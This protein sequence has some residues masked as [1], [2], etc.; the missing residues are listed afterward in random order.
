MYFEQIVRTDIGCAAY[1]I[2]SAFGEAAV[3]DPRLDMVDELLALI[4]REKLRLRYII[5]THNH[6]DHVSGH[7]ALAARTGATIA[8][9]EAAGVAYPHQALRDAEE[10]TLGEVRLRVLHTPGHRPEHIAIAVSDTA[11]GT[12]PWLVLTGDSLFIGDVARPDLAVPGQEGAAALFHSLRERL[13]TLPDGTLVYPAHVSGSLC[14]RVTNRMTMTTL[15]YERAFNPALA[16][17]DEAAFVHYTTE[18]LPERPPNMVR[19]VE[20]NKAA[21]AA[22]AWVG[23]LTPLSASEVSRLRTDGAIVLDVRSVELFTEGHLPGAI[24]VQIESAQFPNRVG[25]TLPAEADLVIV[26]TT[27]AQARAGVAALAIIGH[28][29]VLGFLAG[30]TDA[31]AQAGYPL[32]ALPSWSV[33]MLRERLDGT[34]DILILD[35]RER[36]EWE[37]EHIPGS[38]NIPFYQVSRQRHTLEPTRPIAIV[39]AT[40]HRSAIA[41]SVLQA[42]GFARA[43]NVVGGMAAW[44]ASAAMAD[45][46]PAGRR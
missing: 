38:V 9:H 23:N 31:W 22:T 19:I 46:T 2:G 26:A 34:D 10:L 24:S 8:V 30:G 25:L 29:R 20:L 36:N 42:Q 12:E 27:E 28:T 40:G 37:G 14:G 4:E 11:R 6:A 18:S 3:V 15:G 32:H 43:Y 5:E 33:S 13:L 7:H 21:A 45:L 1:L 39:C 44:N 35:V 17:D 41:A 16:I